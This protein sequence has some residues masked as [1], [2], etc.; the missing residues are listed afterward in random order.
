MKAEPVRLL[1]QPDATDAE[2]ILLAAG[3]AVPAVDYDVEAGMAR[4][5]TQLAAL[6]A[7]GAA[8]AAGAAAGTG[9][10]AGAGSKALLAK[11]AFKIMLGLSVGAAFAGA[12]IVAGMHMARPPQ[13]VARPAPPPNPASPPA[14]PAAEAAPTAP[15][16]GIPEAPALPLATD[17]GRAK[18]DAIRP[19]PRAA[20]RREPPARSPAAA[21]PASG[22]VDG[23]SVEA[24]EVAPPAPAAAR[25]S[26]VPSAPPRPPPEAPVASEPPPAPAPT[27]M[28]EMRA[29][30]LARTLV[31]R[32]PEAALALLQRTERE[33]PTGYFLEERQALTVIALAGAGQRD[34]A[35]QRA[36]VFLRAHPN[37][38][39]SDRVRTFSAP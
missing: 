3:R 35:R 25:P 19:V 39:F 7:A 9:S 20:A 29:V 28:S 10:G 37:G 38:P 12:G 21:Q 11:L 36:L 2:R 13:T 18:P 15:S 31:E 17:P 34:A 6:G 16:P 14:P 33:H 22:G 1:E 27:S 8:T 4:F 26:A 32:D 24:E 23:V 30:A 5:R